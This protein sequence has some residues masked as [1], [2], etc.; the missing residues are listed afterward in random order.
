MKYPTSILSWIVGLFMLIHTGCNP[1]AP[2]YDEEGLANANLL[3]DPSSV[4]G[5]FLLF[6]NAYELRDTTLYGRLYSQN[7]TFAYY[8]FDQGQ[9]IS[10]DRSTEMNIAYNLF[11]SVKLINLDW[12]FYVQLDTTEVEALVVRNFNLFIE[13]DEQTSFNGT[14]RV[15]MRLRREKAGTPWKAYYWF[16]ESD[17]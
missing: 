17:F 13:Q 14:G 12:N 11:R 9:E 15:R 16:D 5:F 2:A 7:F 1:F 6:K 10:W 8:D 3:G 4:D